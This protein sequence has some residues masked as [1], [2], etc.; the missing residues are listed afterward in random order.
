M[1][2]TSTGFCL[3]YIVKEIFI[4]HEMLIHLQQTLLSAKGVSGEAGAGGGTFT[5][6]FHMA[7][8]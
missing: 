5:E 4:F 3:S 7:V 1:C 6:A 8:R 2:S